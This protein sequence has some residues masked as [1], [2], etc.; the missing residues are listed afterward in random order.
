MVVFTACRSK[1]PHC[2]SRPP[3]SNI[4]VQRQ[5]PTLTRVLQNRK[6]LHLD[7][8][9]NLSHKYQT[10]IVVT[11]K[12]QQSMNN[13]KDFITAVKFLWYRGPCYKT[14]VTG[15]AQSSLMLVG[16]AIS[17]PQSGAPERFFNGVGSCFTN[18]HKTRLERLS[19]DKHSSLLRIFVNYVC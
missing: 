12:D 10:R 7:R 2:Q 1:L 8:L 14:L 16:K 18:K 5:E 15:K 3:W 9:H 13:G 17:L 4:C 11:Y 19:K 6:R